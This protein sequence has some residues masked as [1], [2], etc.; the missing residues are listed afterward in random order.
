MRRRS[1]P[2]P[3][4]YSSVD[5]E[6]QIFDISH[7]NQRARTGSSIPLQALPRRSRPRSTVVA[8]APAKDTMF[9]SADMSMVQLYIANEIGREIV[10]ALGELGEV[11][12]RDVRSL[13]ML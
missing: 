1:R 3:S 5:E 12:F 13:L 9:R 2:E 6:E 4:S 10:N 8:M 7:N 11:Q